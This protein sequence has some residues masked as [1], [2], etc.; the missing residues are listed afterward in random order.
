[1]STQSKAERTKL[2]SFMTR[3]EFEIGSSA[4]KKRTAESLV[5]LLLPFASAASPC[6]SGLQQVNWGGRQQ[7]LAMPGTQFPNAVGGK[8]NRAAPLRY[9]N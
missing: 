8:D 4:M 7:S 2:I 1:M 9:G 5:R 6:L 3:G